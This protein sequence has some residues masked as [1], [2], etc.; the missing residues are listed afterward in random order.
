MQALSCLP[1]SVDHAIYDVAISE[2]GYVAAVG[3]LRFDEERLP[4]VDMQRQQDTPP[5]TP[6][7][8]RI[9]GK[10]LTKKGF[11]QALNASLTLEVACFGP[12]C[13]SPPSGKKALVFLK[14]TEAG[15]TL[16][17]NP[18]GGMIFYDPD[19]TALD[20]VKQCYLNGHCPK[21]PRL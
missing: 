15:Y 10:A 9:S 12:W 2:E 11:T 14:K 7:P 16:Q 4:V 13:A 8:A 5:L 6:I 17:T 1:H 21:P 18:C 19:Q 20:K 3:T